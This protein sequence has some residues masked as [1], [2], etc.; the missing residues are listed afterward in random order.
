MTVSPSLSRRN[1]AALEL[2]N[3]LSAV[4]L[5]DARELT[6]CRVLAKDTPIFNQG[7]DRMRAHALIE[8]NVRIAQSGSDGTQT[9]V[10]FIGRRAGSQEV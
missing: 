2:F 6:R 7:D 5:D 3:G 10:R 1:L 4:A 8:G 9:V